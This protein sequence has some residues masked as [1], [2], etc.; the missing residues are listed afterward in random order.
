MRSYCL[1]AAIGWVLLA[2]HLALGQRAETEPSSLAAAAPTPALLGELAALDQLHAEAIADKK[3]L[4]HAVLGAGVVSI[5]GGGAMMFIEASDQAY[6]VAGGCT[7]VFGA[8]DAVIALTS[9]RGIGR[10]ARMWESERPTRNN[11]ARL[12]QTRARWLAAERGEGIAYALNLGLDIAYLSSGLTAVAASQLGAE[13]PERWLAGGL[14]V[15]LQALF[16]VGIDLAGLRQA[17]RLHERLL[18]DLVPSVSM[19]GAFSEPALGVALAGR[20]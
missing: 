7:L 15:S 14:S 1:L 17:G 8:I 19:V 9:L 13:H 18:H 12:Q 2:P 11:A 4:M 3:R 16:L 6:R 20:M 5:A 10:A